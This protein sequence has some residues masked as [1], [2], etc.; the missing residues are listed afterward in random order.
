MPSVQLHAIE[1]LF[2]YHL[3]LALC[4][5][6][7]RGK[8]SESGRQSRHCPVKKRQERTPKLFGYGFHLNDWSV[9]IRFIDVVSNQRSIQAF[10]Y[11][12]PTLTPFFNRVW[13]DGDNQQP[14]H[15]S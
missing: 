7:I 10:A 4:V 3:A 1:T 8:I 6:P 13:Q 2:T 9:A 12:M 14:E 5:K 11:N 15:T